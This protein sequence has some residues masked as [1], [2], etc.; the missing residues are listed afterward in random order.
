[1]IDLLRALATLAEPPAPRHVGVAE[2]LGLDG[3]PDPADHTEL[4]LFQLPPFA[5]VY[6]GPEGKLGGDARDRIAG[7]WRAVGQVPPAEPDHLTALLGLLAGLCEAEA[8]EEDAARRAMVGQGAAALLHEHLLP[9]LGPYLGRVRALAPPFYRRW[10]ELLGRVLKAERERRDPADR[11]AVHLREAPALPD[12]RSGA[13][14]AFLEGL[15]APVVSGLI[16]TRADLA[17]GA[18]RTGVGVRAGERRY[19]LEAMLSQDASAVLRWLATEAGD[20]AIR[21]RALADTA[22]VETSRFWSGRAEATADLLGNL[23]EAAEEA[24]ACQR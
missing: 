5:S 16:L 24:L 22:G 4:F 14:E 17:R 21:H 18:A 19:A 23:G 3:A 2:S 13:T 10:A 20:H 6:L 11:L 8:R 7:F 15:L 9:W 1:M 12:P